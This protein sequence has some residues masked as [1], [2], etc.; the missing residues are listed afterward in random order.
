M[1][2]VHKL[3]LFGHFRNFKVTLK[4]K[5]LTLNFSQKRLYVEVTSTTVRDFSDLP[6]LSYMA[7]SVKNVEKWSLR[8]SKTTLTLT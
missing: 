6:F 2:K 1:Q 5:L 4:L 7:K 8:A 3:G